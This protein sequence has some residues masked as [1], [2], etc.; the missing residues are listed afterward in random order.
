LGSTLNVDEAFFAAQAQVR[1]KYRDPYH[2]AAF[3]L[4]KAN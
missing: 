4:S 3:Y 1:E 2:W